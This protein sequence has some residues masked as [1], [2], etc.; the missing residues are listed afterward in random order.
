MCRIY[1]NGTSAC[2]RD[3]SIC[4]LRFRNRGRFSSNHALGRLLRVWQ[5]SFSPLK[6][7]PTEKYGPGVWWA[8][9]GIHFLLI[10]HLESPALYLWS[11][12]NLTTLSTFLSEWR[13]GT[14]HQKS[15]RGKMGLSMPHRLLSNWQLNTSFHWDPRL[16]MLR[17]LQAS[18]EEEAKGLETQSVLSSCV[19][20]VETK[21]KRNW[22]SA[23][24]GNLPGGRELFWL[25]DSRVRQSLRVL[26]EVTQIAGG[27]EFQS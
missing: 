1:A 22:N 23:H 2:M 12:T 18:V 13:P 17:S 20:P 16:M 19:S 27:R 10:K 11:N 26:R 9:K 24:E 5:K 15:R 8:E 25:C 6:W 3:S 4:R 21:G 14:L 7:G